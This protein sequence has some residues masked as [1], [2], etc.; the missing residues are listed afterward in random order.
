[1]STFTTRTNRQLHESKIEQNGEV[2][3]SRI[4][5]INELP[6]YVNNI[7]GKKVY[8]PNTK[9]TLDLAQHDE[10]V[11]YFSTSSTMNQYGIVELK[12]SYYDENDNFVLFT[13]SNGTIKKKVCNNNDTTRLSNVLREIDTTDVVIGNPEGC[14][15]NDL[16]WYIY[17]TKKDFILSVNKLFG[18]FKIAEILLNNDAISFGY[19]LPKKYYNVK[20]GK[21]ENRGDMMWITSFKNGNNPKIIETY[22]ETRFHTYE[23]YDNYDA[24]NVDCVK[25]IPMDYKGVMGVPVTN[26]P[27]LNLNQFKIIG[28]RKGTDGKDLCINGKYTHTRILISFRNN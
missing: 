8:I 1:M 12:Y 2:F 17:E 27:I 22:Y 7:R 13:I 21:V 14:K 18:G 26:L 11:K 28:F 24:I 15:V 6:H 16:V 23:K 5:I 3:I 20:N 10:F 9:K 4:E 25:M 19:N